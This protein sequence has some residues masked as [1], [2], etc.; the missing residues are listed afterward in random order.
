MMEDVAKV[1]AELT[2]AGA[3]LDTD[4]T[5][6]KKTAALQDLDKIYKR[7]ETVVIE[8]GYSPEDFDA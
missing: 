7:A 4:E 6:Q 2:H 8:A 5:L 3:D 1:T